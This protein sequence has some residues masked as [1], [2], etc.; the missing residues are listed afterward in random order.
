MSDPT[1]LT[2]TEHAVLSVLSDLGRAYGLQIVQASEGALRRASIYVL[3]GRLQDKGFVQ[4]HLEDRMAG[5]RGPRRRVYRITATGHRVL[6]AWELA[7]AI[8][9]GARS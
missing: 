5:Q 3:L 4:S 6:S 2:V 9:I 7:R 8:M 1:Q